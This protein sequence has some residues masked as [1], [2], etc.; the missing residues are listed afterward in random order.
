MI[1]RLLWRLLAA[2]GEVWEQH[3][4]GYLPDD[5]TPVCWDCPRPCDDLCRTRKG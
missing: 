5:D 3:G 4:I 1:A 2:L